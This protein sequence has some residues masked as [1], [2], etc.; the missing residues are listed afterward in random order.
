MLHANAFYDNTVNNPDNPSSPPKTVSAGESTTDEMMLVFF[1]YTFYQPGD[2]NINMEGSLAV[3]PEAPYYSGNQMLQPYPVPAKD[4]LIAKYFFD[5]SSTA[6]MDI[7]D[8]TGR[9]VKNVFSDERISEGYSTTNISV[10]GIANGTYYLR[11][12]TSGGEQVQ[13]IIVAR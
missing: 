9:V 11:L 7:I 1:V 4:Q 13:K 3:G 10:S 6:S 2:E 12:K 5:K 8:M